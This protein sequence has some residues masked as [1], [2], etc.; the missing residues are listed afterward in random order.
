MLQLLPM[1]N[2]LHFDEKPAS[3][4]LPEGTVPF[5]LNF[6]SIIKDTTDYWQN[7]DTKYYQQYTKGSIMAGSAI[8]TTPEYEKIVEVLIDNVFQSVRDDINEK[9]TD[10]DL[11]E[12]Q[13]ALKKVSAVEKVFQAGVMCLKELNIKLDIN[14]VLTIL[15][16]SLNESIHKTTRQ[17]EITQRAKH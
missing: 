2:K 7:V 3:E 4:V 14:S 8:S 11:E 12:K 17:Y 13:E 5:K 10:S 6:E 1:N 9:Y 15:H 16:G